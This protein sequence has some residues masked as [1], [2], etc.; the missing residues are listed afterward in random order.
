MHLLETF[1]DITEMKAAQAA[2][3][4]ASAQLKASE[5]AHRSIFEN[6]TYGIYRSSVGGGFTTVNRSLVRMLGYGSTE[7]LMRIDVEKDLYA[8]PSARAAL[9]GQF[10]HADVFDNVEIPW[11]RKDGEI[12]TVRLSGRVVHGDAGDGDGFEVFV[13]DVSERRALEDQLRLAQKLESVGQLAAGIAHEIN[14]P[15]QYIG[16]TVH[17]LETSVEDYR[18]L[19]TAYRATRD[20]I[21]NTDG[22]AAVLA[23]L[24]EAE[25]LADLEYLEEH[26]PRAFQRTKEGVEHVSKIVRAMKEFSH[27]DQREKAPVD[28]NR[29]IDST[30][31]VGRNEYKYVAEVDTDFGDLPP[32]KCHV[33]ELN[34]VFLNLIVNAAHAI[35]EVIDRREEKGKIYIRTELEDEGT[36]LVTIRDTGCGIPDDAQNNVFNPFYTTKEVGRG[37]GQGLS[38]ARSVVVEKHGGSLTFETEVGAGTAFFI[39]LPTDGKD[40]GV[41]EQSS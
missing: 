36:V 13:E 12:I 31:T 3:E 9:I 34:Q 24:D 16:D 26:L 29:A 38:I 32:V 22:G 37:T 8:D 15:M 10:S 21:G 6:A 35:D 19:L 20:V 11:K 5:E 25:E 14:T 1:V 17:F 28:L 23:E 30:L 40:G 18:A 7:E 33:S 27:P 2:R 4:E 39:R 41:E